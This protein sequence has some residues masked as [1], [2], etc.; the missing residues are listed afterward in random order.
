MWFQ[1]KANC[2]RIQE[3]KIT[4]QPIITLQKNKINM[5]FD[6]VSLPPL[7]SV[8]SELKLIYGS[9]KLIYR[10]LIETKVSKDEFV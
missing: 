9:P 1:K 4:I 6:E 5:K 10:L 8:V 2:K 3:D 7:E